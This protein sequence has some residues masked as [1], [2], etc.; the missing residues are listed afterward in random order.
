MIRR[1]LSIILAAGLAAGLVTGCGSEKT[2]SSGEKA[3]S[4]ETAGTAESS[5][6]SAETAETTAAADSS[7]SG[8]TA[9]VV[10]YNFADTFISNARQTLNNLSANDKTI[11]VTD[12]DSQND[13]TIQDNNM[14]NIFTQH[15]D[16]FILN[17][18]N[19]AGTS[20]I[21]ESCKNEGI[22]TIF[23]NCSSPSDEDF[24]NYEDLWYVSSASEQSGTN[25]GNQIVEYF[26]SHD[27]WDRNGNGKVDFILL[28]G[29][30]TFIDTI[31][32][33]SFSL[34]TIEEA[35]F[36]LGTNIGGDDV[37]GVKGGDSLNGVICDFQ[38][39]KAQENVEALIASYGDDIDCILA[40]NDDEALGAIAALQAHGYFTDESKYIPVVGVDATAAGCEAI[41]NGTML[42]TSLNN[43]VKLGKSIYKLMYLLNAGEEVTTESIAIDGV[44]VTD[45]KIIIDYI[46][47]TS[48]NLEEAEYDI[49]DTSF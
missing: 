25:M 20:Q 46:P 8:V 47:I 34:A 49:N 31:N 17:N 45:H 32:R 21:V 16:Y 23:A 38:R 26:K 9:G 7:A 30:P 3:A 22:T 24:K 18:I 37:Q 11:A 33:S 15:P 35:G 12:A 40:D 2:G 41:K 29:M 5:P 28:Q 19:N 27:N 6:A 13:T 42:G 36:E 39:A 4:V 48:E 14:N 10:W 1:T 44:N 43:P